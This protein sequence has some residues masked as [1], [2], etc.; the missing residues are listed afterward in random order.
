MKFILKKNRTDKNGDMYD[1]CTEG[2][3]GL[4]VWGSVH[5]DFINEA[6]IARWES[7]VGFPDEIEVDD[8]TSS[9]IRDGLIDTLHH[10][11]QEGE[12][13]HESIERLL[14]LVEVKA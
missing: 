12:L 9:E 5:C 6:D 11:N 8:F 4:H 13:T 10:I 2:N 3:D 1:V 7:G 14:K